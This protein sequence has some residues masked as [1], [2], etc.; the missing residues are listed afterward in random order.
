[1]N[2]G[3][4]Y[5]P[6]YLTHNT[7]QH[8]ENA[9]RLEA[10]ISYLEKTGLKR[11][12]EPVAPRQAT[13]EEVA[14]V[15]EEP[16]IAHIRDSAARGGGWLDPDTVMSSGSYETALC[17]AGGVIEATDAVI[18]GKLSSAFALVRPP[19]HHAT[20]GRAMGFCLFNNVAI[21]TRY[22]ITQ[23]GLERVAIVDFDVHHGNGTQETFYGSPQVLYV[24]TH[25]SPLFPGTGQIGET[26]NALGK[27]KTV[28]I[29]LPGGCGDIEYEQVFTQVVVPAVDRFQPQLIMVSAGYDGHWADPLA[30][31]QLSVSGFARI[32]EII[33]ELAERWCGGRIV[34]SLE[35]GYNLDALS[36]SV[37]ATF[38]M[39][40]GKNT[41]D[42]PMGKSSSQF[43][44]PDIS[45]SL[46]SVKGIHGL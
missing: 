41:V 4:V 34:I 29:P 11:E 7:G 12:L 1:M 21:G 39:L 6:V 2:V 32:V 15:H 14:M 36:A 38:D 19:G 16:Y 45:S 33:R 42:D 20:T 44:A 35:G 13:L 31:M 3:I 30:M 26:G 22:A 17:A 25:E 37:K 5:D 43:N 18:S 9:R 10:I 40:L 27:G 28:N 24:S 23:C 8:V 46:A